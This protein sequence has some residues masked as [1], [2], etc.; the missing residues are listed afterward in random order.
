MGLKIDDKLVSFTAKRINLPLIYYKPPRDDKMKLKKGFKDENE[1]V[2]RDLNRSQKASWDLMNVGF[3]S[4]KDMNQLHTL[5]LNHNGYQKGE[6]MSLNNVFAAKLREYDMAITAGYAA[7]QQYNNLDTELAE[8]F[9][10][11]ERT[12][13][14]LVLVPGKDNTDIYSKVKR[15]SDLTNGKHTLCAVGSKIRNSSAEQRSQL[16]ANLCL[17]VNMKMQGEP[18]VPD[19]PALDR[20]MNQNLRDSTLI[21]GAVGRALALH[22]LS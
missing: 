20:I 19:L 9:S 10:V 17:K 15:T 18:H 21:L 11:C 4:G 8:W 2:P 3:Y 6:L 14:S 12:D 1:P 7:G 16:L 22:I 13:C 5:G